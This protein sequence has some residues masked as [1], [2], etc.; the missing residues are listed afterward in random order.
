MQHVQGGAHASSP[1]AA[2]SQP[3]RRS[4]RALHGYAQGM[5]MQLPGSDTLGQEVGA[6]EEACGHQLV[7]V[8]AGALAARLIVVA[9]REDALGSPVASM[10]APT[11]P[12]LD[13]ACGRRESRCVLFVAVVSNSRPSGPVGLIPMV[14]AAPSRA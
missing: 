14:Y 11:T 1:Y 9:D 13:R 2:V 6:S 7:D 10:S 3:R 4:S 5:P 8:G 12:A